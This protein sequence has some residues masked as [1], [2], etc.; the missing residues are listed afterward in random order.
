MRT[1][2]CS[3]CSV[4]RYP[5]APL[6]TMICSVPLSDSYG[7][8]GGDGQD[9]RQGDADVTLTPR[10]LVRT[11][12]GRAGAHRGA[13]RG[14]RAARGGRVSH[15]TRARGAQGGRAMT[16][17]AIYARKSQDDSELEAEARQIEG[18]RRSATG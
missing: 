9:R 2:T 11:P 13:A 6:D 15:A 1:P 7:Y 5:L 12:P 18:A 8:G 10:R 17:C 16:V 4:W 14:H 3:P